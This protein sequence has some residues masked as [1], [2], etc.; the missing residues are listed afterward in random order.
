MDSMGMVENW[1]AS[2]HQGWRAHRHS[3]EWIAEAHRRPTTEGASEV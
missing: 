3:R 2:T 1:S